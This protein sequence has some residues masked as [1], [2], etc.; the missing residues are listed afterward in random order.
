MQAGA[1]RERRGESDQTGT[2]LEESGSTPR[3]IRDNSSNKSGTRTG[4]Q[5]P[6]LFS[7]ELFLV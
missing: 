2:G 5:A 4:N 3:G 1:F 6:V 7:A